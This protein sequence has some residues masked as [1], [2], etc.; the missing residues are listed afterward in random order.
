MISRSCDSTAA[1]LGQKG[2]WRHDPDALVAAQWKKVTAVC[3]HQCVG[4]L[5]DGAGK[6]R[7]VARLPGGRDEVDL[8]ALN[9]ELGAVVRETLQPSHVS[10]WLRTPQQRR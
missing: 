2:L 5:R 4:A 1:Q 7:I 10:L 8:G 6:D 9:A 3:G